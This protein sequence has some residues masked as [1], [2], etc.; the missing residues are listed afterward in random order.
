[1]INVPKGLAPHEVDLYIS[2]FKFCEKL[3]QEQ[4]TDIGAA[5]TETTE[6]YSFIISDKELF[7]Q[8]LFREI[9]AYTEPS[10]G[11]VSPELDDKTWWSKLK[12]SEKFIPEYWQRY[13]DYL[14][15]KPSWSLTAVQDIDSSTDEI[16]NALANPRSGRA[17]D[18]MGMVF[19]YVQSGKTAHYIGLINKAVDAGYRIV[20]VLTGIHNSL[21]SQTQSR[22]D[23]EVLGY[24]TSLENL[25][26]MIREPNVIG[27][28]IGAHNRVKTIVQSI[29]TRDEKGDVNKTTEG[30]SMVPPFIIVTKKN[31]TVLRRILRF[32]RKNQCAEVIDGKK[33]ITAKY[34]ALIIDDEADQASINT[35]DSY[36]EK[37]NLLDDYNPTTINGLIREILKTFECRSYVGYKTCQTNYF[38]ELEESSDGYQAYEF[39]KAHRA[40]IE[41]VNI[42]FLTNDEVVQFVPEDISYGKISIKFDVWDI[43]RLYQSIFSGTAVERQLVIKLKKKYAAPLHLIKVNGSNDTYDCYIG[44]ISGELLAR[45]YKDEGQ[46]LMPQT[47]AQILRP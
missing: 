21:R 45:I 29:T 28:G 26:D 40:D 24:E 8:F 30:V 33:I 34:P 32:F 43:E 15:R 20:V 25:A 47:Y 11:V 18:R 10:I 3:I 38:E 35:N 4:N 2:A 6:K 16:M 5:V 17:C 14:N 41:T 13:Y 7:A 31:A 22:I 19:G 12:K 44:V 46:E 27:V 42:I 9:T 23:E 37:G 1:M 36:D 39:I